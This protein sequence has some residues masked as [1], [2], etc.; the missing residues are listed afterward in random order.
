M[1]RILLIT[2]VVLLAVGAAMAQGVTTASMTG[3]VKDSKGEAIPGA[4]VIATHTPSGTTYGVA[5]RA[6]GYY[7]LLGMRVGGPYTVKVTF[8][9]YKEQ[10][11][12]NIYLQLGQSFV[13]DFVL[14]DDAT[15]LAEVVVTSAVDPTLNSNKMGT[16]TNFGFDWS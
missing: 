8:I 13:S 11:V 4:S 7:N 15:Q 3:I 10:V 16:S 14:I 5:S 9:G 1:R 12:E 6:D 2:A